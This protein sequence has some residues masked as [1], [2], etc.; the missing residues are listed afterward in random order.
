M[1]S[2]TAD[3][4]VKITQIVAAKEIIRDKI[5][6][7]DLEEIEVKIEE[8]VKRNPKNPKGRRLNSNRGLG[9]DSVSV[10]IGRK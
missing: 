4:V 2:L 8:E 9:V 6:L 1:R 7:R 3:S 5:F 10:D